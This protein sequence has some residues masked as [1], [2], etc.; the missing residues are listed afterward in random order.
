MPT[1]TPPAPDPIVAWGIG[2]IAIVVAITWA[3]TWSAGVPATRTRLLAVSAAIMAVSAAVARSGLLQRFDIMPPPMGLLIVAVL[4]VALAFGLSPL[5]ASVAA[6]VPLAVLIGVQ[7]FRFPLEL[8]MH[9]GMTL[10]IVPQALSYGGLNYDILT[11][12]G[13]LAL[14]AALRTGAPVPRWA[15]WAWNVWGSWCLVVIVGVAIT[16]S[17]MLRLFGD[18][19]RQV[20]TWVL[21]FPYVWVPAILVANAI[22]THIV[23]TRAL[24]R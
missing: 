24:L 19:P 15:I 23:V 4:A 3:I 8:L 1:I 9:R 14:V 22:A 7:A 10:G 6:S 17:P 20:N 18:D 2:L 12:L 11:G 5:G 21:F 16:A 13:A